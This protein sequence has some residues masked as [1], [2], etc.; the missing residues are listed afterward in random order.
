MV[1]PIVQAENNYQTQ[2]DAQAALDERID[3]ATA[4]ALTE[5]TPVELLNALSEVDIDAIG[6]GTFEAGSAEDLFSD[7]LFS[8][9]QSGG[10]T[11]GTALQLFIGKR[12]I[13]LVFKNHREHE[14]EP[15]IDD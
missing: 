12:V 3:Q 8:I 4:Q 6:A 15:F 13:E 10:E 5:L 1:D 2:E 11:K 9:R 14:I 7:L